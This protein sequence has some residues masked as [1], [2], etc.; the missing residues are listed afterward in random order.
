M[1]RPKK[2][3]LCHVSIAGTG[4]RASDNLQNANAKTNP[5]SVRAPSNSCEIQ[6]QGSSPEAGLETV[7]SEE[8]TRLQGISKEEDDRKQVEEQYDNDE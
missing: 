6:N 3:R 1:K 4:A 5:R 2:E 7:H 8:D